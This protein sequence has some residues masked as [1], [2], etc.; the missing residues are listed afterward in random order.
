MNYYTIMHLCLPAQQQSFNEVLHGIGLM[1][2]HGG[3]GEKN[4]N[5]LLRNNLG[6]HVGSRCS[7]LDKMQNMTLRYFSF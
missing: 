3:I 6:R 7:I 4:T 2:F 5:M 1:H